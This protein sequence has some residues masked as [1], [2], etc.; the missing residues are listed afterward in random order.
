MRPPDNLY[1][2]I[3]QPLTQY[4]GIRALVLGGT[5]FIGQWVARALYAQ[6]ADVWL[7]VRD[8]AAAATLHT[9]RNMHVQI[10]EIDLA[11]PESVPAL[12][13]TLRPMITFNLAGY[14]V[15]KQ[16]QDE[17][18]FHRINTALVGAICEAAGATR[19]LGWMG[20][21]VVH[22]GSA[23][24]YG[25]I[26]GN[27]REDSVP[28]PTTRYG[29]SKLAGTLY[30]RQCCEAH[31]LRGITARLFTVYGPGEHTGRLL[32]S[33]IEAARTGNRLKLSAGSQRRDF[34]YVEDV[35]E[36]LLR[37]GLAPA[38][39]GEI[40]NLA[41][42]RLS[43]VRE[44]AETAARILGISQDQLLFGA[45][46][47]QDSEMQHSEVALER[48]QQVIQWAPQTDIEKGIRKSIRETLCASI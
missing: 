41:T 14:G 20:Q 6:G 11:Q 26:P 29:Q 9:R 13:Q 30:L 45:L 36:G 31:E 46:P 19:D 22:T 1:S 10:R 25:T 38:V 17:T 3:S 43:S 33:L 7:G 32:P 47:M 2:S 27:L 28:N 15:D 42:G 44:F 5:G 12:F 16:E 37:L 48:L 34:T 4:R 40:V 18:E 35:A 8:R 21:A 39:P 23:L 24:E